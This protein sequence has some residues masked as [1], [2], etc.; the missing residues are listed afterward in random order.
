MYRETETQ[1]DPASPAPASAP[2]TDPPAV[3]ALANLRAG[4][5]LPVTS[6]AGAERVRDLVRLK[7]EEDQGRDRAVVIE[8]RERLEWRAR[9]Q[10]QQELDSHREQQLDGYIKVR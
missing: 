6:E 4:A 2:G 5:G 3:L 7:Q 10:E 8:E 9:Q 1:T